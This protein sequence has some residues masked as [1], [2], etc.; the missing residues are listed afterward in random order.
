M[1]RIC[2]TADVTRSGSTRLVAGL[3]L[4][5]CLAACAAP[6]G[7]SL[8]RSSRAPEVDAAAQFLRGQ[9]LELEGK[10]VDAAAAY[11]AAL[12]VDPDSAELQRRAAQVWARMG[13]PEKALAYAQR[14]YALDPDDEKTRGGLAMLLVA[15]KRYGE[16]VELM[17]PRFESG[18]LSQDGMFALFNLYMEM[19]ELAEAE[20]VALRMVELAPLEAR[21]HF[22]LGLAFERQNRNDEARRAYRRG[23]AELPGEPRFFDALARLAQR[24]EDKPAEMKVLEQKL[25]AFPE[26]IASLRRMAQIE[27]DSGNRAGAVEILETLVERSPDQLAAQF[28]LGF[29]YFE[30]ERFADAI[31]RFRAVIARSERLADRR[32][33]DEVRYFMGRAHY[34]NDDPPGALVALG[35]IEPGSDRYADS[36]IVMARIH[37]ENDDVAAA[38]AEVRR[39]AAAVPDNTAVQ[40]Y[41]AGLLQRAGDADGAIDLMQKLIASA[42]DDAELYYDLGVI[43]GN[44]GQDTDAIAQMVLVLDRDADHASALNYVGYSWAESGERLEEAEAYIRRAVEQRPDDGYIADSLGWVFYQKG[45]KR[46]AEG[47]AAQARQAFEQA[48]EQLERALSLLEEGDPVITRHLADA[49]R[50]VSRFTDA[51]STYRRALE[52]DPEEDDAHEI[53]Q[54][55]ELLE[56]Q[57]HGNAGGIAR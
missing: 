46:L 36:R 41:L 43:Y 16:A 40:T 54:H 13:E 9:M 33:V 38:L 17:K 3:V 29:Y 51:L 47:D 6:S 52:L 19:G 25:R 50:S 35:E 44:A 27:E 34:A 28:Q 11:D 37:E 15:A 26:D 42:P 20:R 39:S 32:W 14:A 12:E 31:E 49:Y 10:L 48:I 2:E 22:T 55:I 18:E 53:R 24:E 21:P 45:L 57:L 4:A 5:V 1:S 56:A 8:G 30:A 7:P 23:I